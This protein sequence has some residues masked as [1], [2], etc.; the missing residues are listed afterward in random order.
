LNAFAI[1][2]SYL[3]LLVS[4]KEEWLEPKPLSFYAPENV[5]VNEQGLRAILPTLRKDLKTECYNNLH[6]FFLEYACSDLASSL[7]I[8]DYI[9]LTPSS[10]LS[11]VT[12]LSDVYQFIKNANVLISRIDAVKWDNEQVRNSILAEGYFYRSHWYYRLVHSYG[13]VPWIGEELKG[14]KLD[15]FTYSTW[16]ILKK[17]QTDMEFAV[18]WLPEKAAIGEPTK[19]AGNMLLTKIY[20]SNAEF[21]KAIA[22]ASVVI[23]GPFALMKDRF[24]SYKSKTSRNVIWDLHRAENKNLPENTETIFTL[25]DRLEAPTDARSVGLYAAR[26]YVCHW[27]SWPDSRGTAGVSRQTP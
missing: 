14:A 26:T 10:S 5:Y 9:I 23:N 4:C 21:D 18:Q 24:G 13:D 16:A 22:S 8:Q 15:F 6:P 20:L 3:I 1:L 11:F 25:I 19:Y 2:I 12:R 17:I 7:Q 27:W